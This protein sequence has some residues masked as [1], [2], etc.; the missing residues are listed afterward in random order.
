MLLLSSAVLFSRVTFSKNSFRNTFRVSNGLD[1][2]QDRISVCPDLGPNCLKRLSADDMLL[3]LSADLSNL[4]FFK[5]FFKE[6]YQSVKRFGKVFSRRQKLS[7][8]RAELS[9]LPE[10][11]TPG[12]GIKVTF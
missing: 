9:S 10:G 11:I 7:L 1:P 4:T 2:D 5:K 12:S 6:H 3:L 8:A